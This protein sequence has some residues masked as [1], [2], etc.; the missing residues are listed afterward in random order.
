VLQ[1]GHH[2]AHVIKDG[3]LVDRGERPQAERPLAFPVA[4][5]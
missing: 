5:A 4:T 3:K 2:L 1:G